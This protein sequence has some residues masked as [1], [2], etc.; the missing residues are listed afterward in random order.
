M[1]SYYW[2]IWDYKQFVEFVTSL[3]LTKSSDRDFYL[4]ILTPFI[5]NENR[6]PDV[7]PA[8]LRWAVLILKRKAKNTINATKTKT[9]LFVLFS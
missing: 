2:L 3:A 8:N 9:G 4:T 6:D 5:S 7:T 1:P